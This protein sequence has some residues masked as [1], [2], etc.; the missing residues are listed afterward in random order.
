MATRAIAAPGSSRAWA[1]VGKRG[2]LLQAAMSRI[3]AAPM[4]IRKRRPLHSCSASAANRRQKNLAHVAH[5]AAFLVRHCAGLQ[6]LCHDM[7]RERPSEVETLRDV[8]AA[9]TQEVQLLDGLDALRHYTLAECVGH[10]DDGFDQR[11]GSWI[12][13]HFL[14]E[15]AIDL[16]RA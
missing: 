5:V 15:G 6:Q 9:L 1:A 2:V 12:L 10:H 4:G 13:R 14:E 16:H 3:N 8:A 11:S 7:R